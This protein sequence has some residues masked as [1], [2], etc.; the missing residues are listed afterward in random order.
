MIEQMMHPV[1]QNS[2]AWDQHEYDAHFMS[3][4]KEL[5]RLNAH[6]D[7][8]QANAEPHDRFGGTIVDLQTGRLEEL[9][10]RRDELLAEVL[11]EPATAF[12][13]EFTELSRLYEGR[14]RHDWDGLG[15]KTSEFVTR[16]Q[17]RQR[18]DLHFRR[19][20]Y[21]SGSTER[22]VEVP[23]HDDGALP[24]Y[25]SLKDDHLRLAATVYQRGGYE[26]VEV[27]PLSEPGER[28]LIEFFTHSITASGL[29]YNRTSDEIGQ[30][31][32]QAASFLYAKQAQLRR[33]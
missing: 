21:A 24:F 30:A 12:L 26:R 20:D 17:T 14:T 22:V 23:R 4:V 15:T 8:E 31:D 2:D 29:V 32:R 18:A 1:E 6:I 5:I 28:L 11:A 16:D 3:I 19:L 7:A 10:R 13:H 25:I 27:D 33:V 9:V